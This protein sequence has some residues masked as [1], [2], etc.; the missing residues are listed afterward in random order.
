MIFT[1]P[2]GH[3]E[4]RRNCDHVSVNRCSFDKLLLST[5]RAFPLSGTI[6]GAANSYS[7]AH[8]NRS[9]VSFPSRCTGRPTESIIALVQNQEG[10]SWSNAGRVAQGNLR[11]AFRITR[12]PGCRIAGTS[13]PIYISILD[14][15]IRLWSTTR[16]PSATEL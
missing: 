10:F 4:A 11:C 12:S 7:F 3:V 13:G 6:L 15:N 9:R 1:V 2:V 14:A 16:S 5:T 8:K